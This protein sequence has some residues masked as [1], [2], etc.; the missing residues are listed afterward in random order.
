[1]WDILVQGARSKGLRVAAADVL[2]APARGL[3]SRYPQLRMALMARHTGVLLINYSVR[4]LT[5]QAGVADEHRWLSHS[6]EA[7]YDRDVERIPPAA[8]QR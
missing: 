6:V 7:A 1:M 3:P 8:V 4:P 2:Q 5:L